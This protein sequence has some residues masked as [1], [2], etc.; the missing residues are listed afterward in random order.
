MVVLQVAATGVSTFALECSAA[1]AVGDVVARAVAAHAAAAAAAPP[2]A[3]GA[4]APRELDA[5]SAALYFLRKPLDPAAKLGA[6]TGGSERCKLAVALAR[7][8]DGP[9]PRPLCDPETEAAMLAYY[10]QRQQEQAR[11]AAAA[12]DDAAGAREAGS[13]QAALRGVGDVRIR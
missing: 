5:A 4:P 11:L 7:R 6:Y 8:A 10:F 12:E 2:P 13:L 9:P 3:A 1:D